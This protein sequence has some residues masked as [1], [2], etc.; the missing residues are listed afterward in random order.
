M[1]SKLREPFILGHVKSRQLRYGGCFRD[2]IM[3]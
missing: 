3:S 2:G 1:Y